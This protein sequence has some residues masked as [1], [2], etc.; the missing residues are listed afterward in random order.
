MLF[1]FTKSKRCSRWPRSGSMSTKLRR[2]NKTRLTITGCR[3][4]YTL[5]VA[6]ARTLVSMDSQLDSFTPRI[7]ISWP[8]LDLLSVCCTRF[9]RIPSSF[10]KRF[11]RMRSGLMSSFKLRRRD[12]KRLEQPSRMLLSLLAFHFS[13][14]RELSW[15]GLMLEAY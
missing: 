12:F 7:R 13:S 10:C 2:I 1:L 14:R 9:P 3:I 5:L 6:S 4:M 15:P 8:H 11:L